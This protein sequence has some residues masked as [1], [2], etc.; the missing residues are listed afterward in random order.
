MAMRAPGFTR[1]AKP[2]AASCFRT[3]AE[4]S[5]IR[6][7]GNFWRTR[8]NRGNFMIAVILSGSPHGR[9]GLWPVHAP[10]GAR[11]SEIERSEHACTNLSASGYIPRLHQQS[12]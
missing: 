10:Q 3:S 7:S 12:L 6:R 9:I 2:D 1:E 4:T 5:G 8:I 11:K